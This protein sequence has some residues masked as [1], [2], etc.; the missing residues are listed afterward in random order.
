MSLVSIVV[1]FLYFNFE[2]D[3]IKVVYLIVLIAYP[4]ICLIVNLVVANN[5][6]SHVLKGSDELP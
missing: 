4:L 1:Y 3:M 5:L 6:K 2:S